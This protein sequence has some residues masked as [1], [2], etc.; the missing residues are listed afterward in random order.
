MRPSS[1]GLYAWTVPNDPTLNAYVKVVAHDA[2]GKS[3]EDL[4]DGAFVISD[5]TA[6]IVTV[7]VPNGGENW[8]VGSVHHITWTATDNVGVTSVDLH[9]STTGA[10][11][12]F[13]LIAGGEANDGVYSWTVPDNPSADAYVKVVA[14][15]AAANAGQDL[16]DSA[17][18]ISAPD[19]ITPTVTVWAPNGGETWAAGSTENI[20]W[21]ATDN[22]AVTSVD[23]YYS[24]DGGTSFKSIATGETN[25]GTYSWT[26]PNDPTTS[27]YVKV[28]AYDAAGNT[29][30]DLSDAPFTIAGAPPSVVDDL[31]NADIAVAG[32]VSGVGDAS[33]GTFTDTH[34]SDNLYE[35][36]TEEFFAKN[37]SRLEHKWT[38][39][40]TGGSAV[41]FNVE[42][43]RNSNAD[44]NFMFAYSTDDVT[45]MD[46]VAVASTSD[47]V[48]SFQ[49][50]NTLSGNVFVRVVDT[51]RDRGNSSLD[52]IYVDHMYI[53][54]SGEA[55]PVHDVAVTGVTALPDPA[56]QGQTVTVTVDVANQ[57]DSAETFVVNATE[58]PDNND[59]GTQTVTNL[60]AGGTTT[61]TFSWVTDAATTLGD[62]TITATAAT[63]A[64]EMD[65]ADNTGS[66]SV[67]V[68]GNGNANDMYVLQQTWVDE[69]VRG[70]I[71]LH[72]TVDV[73]RDS[74]ANAV[75]EST[76]AAVPGAYVY[77]RV[78]H[79]TDGDG[80]FEPGL[81]WP[82]SGDRIW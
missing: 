22:V 78:I 50:P 14:H 52:T 57:G 20:T 30:E 19:T 65:T 82:F 74:N 37:R 49:L 27:A 58:S 68:G 8:A 47:Q 43:H 42:A 4:S 28:V 35:A 59:L 81:G 54:S 33:T 63:V 75:A 80:L 2:A 34:S 64:G 76:D 61:V 71:N 18:T 12:A 40:V 48:Y 29:G 5:Q 36:I 67:T 66:T 53:R 79:D 9:Y 44:D 13:S 38:F 7:T 62:H 60:A 6:P 73:K 31:A 41:T 55:A 56:T 11:G 21:N 10:S 3:G 24:N 69:K 45:Y 15:D 77:F 16:S 46:M 39:D 23:L 17:F 70:K 32:T 51:N 72:V 1:D 26:V 25:D